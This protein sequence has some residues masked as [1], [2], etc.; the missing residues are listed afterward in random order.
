VSRRRLEEA[1]FNFELRV[2][3]VLVGGAEAVA[4]V[5][6]RVRRSDRNGTELLDE[7]LLKRVLN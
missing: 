5:P 1:R 3:D 6:R 7:E 4:D 2:L